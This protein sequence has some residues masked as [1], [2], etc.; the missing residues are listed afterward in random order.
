MCS[1]PPA[2]VIVCACEFHTN[3]GVVVPG[4]HRLVLSGRQDEE[5]GVVVVELLDHL[6]PE[7][8]LVEATEIRWQLLRDLKPWNSSND[9]RLARQCENDSAVLAQRWNGRHL[10]KGTAIEECVDGR[11][12][13]VVPSDRVLEVKAVVPLQGRPA[14]VQVNDTGLALL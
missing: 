3:D 13:R 9:A 14:S 8:A 7:Q 2:D 11:C 10:A 5:V 1:S 12:D 6:A 4:D